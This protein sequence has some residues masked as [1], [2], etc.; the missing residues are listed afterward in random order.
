MAG[1]SESIRSGGKDM[2]QS[3]IPGRLDTIWRMHQIF[4]AN[5]NRAT[6]CYTLKT[7]LRPC[8]WGG[9]LQG[10]KSGIFN[11]THYYYFFLHFLSLTRP[12]PFLILFIHFIMFPHGNFPTPLISHQ[13]LCALPSF[14][15]FPV[16]HILL[17]WHVTHVTS[18]CLIY[19]W[20]SNYT[21]LHWLLID[22]INLPVSMF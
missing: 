22:Y 20:S 3:M 16:H 14:I 4:Y 12:N 18:V 11:Y 21:A 1:R 8:S 15:I 9:I 2:I 10:I 7:W 19:L 13:F 6:T 17:M 5:L